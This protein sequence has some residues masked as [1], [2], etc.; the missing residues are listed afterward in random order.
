MRLPVNG[1]VGVVGAGELEVSVLR[2]HV[3][4]V[5]K[6]G[7][8][9]GGVIFVG[10]GIESVIL[11]LKEPGMSGAKDHN[12]AERSQKEVPD[13]SCDESDDIGMIE[14]CS[15]GGPSNSLRILA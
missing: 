11:P 14:S 9:S 13:D 3:V 7:V 8:G 4:L 1:C 5:R 6:V 12:E 10:T 2:V 15:T